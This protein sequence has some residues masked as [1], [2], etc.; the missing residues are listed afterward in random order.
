MGMDF[1][2]YLW[3][4]FQ[5][6]F[7]SPDNPVWALVAWAAFVWWLL[8]WGVPHMSS[9]RPLQWLSD[10]IGKWRVPILILL[11]LGSV[12]AAGYSMQTSYANQQAQDRPIMIFNLQA[13]ELTVSSDNTT[14]TID[15]AVQNIG[16]NPAYNVYSKVLW[17]AESELQNIYYQESMG[18][19][20][21]RN[22]NQ[23]ML[24]VKVLERGCDRWY[25]YYL[26]EYSDAADKGTEY[27]DAYWY[28]LDFNSQRLSDL[29]PAQKV[30][31]QPYVDAFSATEGT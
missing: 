26:I 3:Q 30:A 20:P 29:T 11:I 31:F 18:V 15:F 12:I 6:A 25:I 13:S 24:Q 7:W 19:N 9:R 16:V 8:I 23:V 27:T 28:S 22:P 2:I 4:L 1:G 21:I 10:R 17:A 5:Y 14:A